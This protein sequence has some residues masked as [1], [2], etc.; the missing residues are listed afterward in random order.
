MLPGKS[1]NNPL[2][3]GYC[4]INPARMLPDIAGYVGE[5]RFEPTFSLT[6]YP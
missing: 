1:C 3:G 6:N 4:R 2:R 5:V